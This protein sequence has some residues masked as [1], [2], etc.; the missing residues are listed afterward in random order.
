[1]NV[2]I[3]SREVGHGHP[4]YVIAELSANHGQDYQRARELLYVAK[5]AGADAVK[6]Q[7][8]TADTITINCD[9]APFRVKDGT[10][11][12]GRTL[13]ELYAEAFT[14]WEWQPELKR[15]ADALGIDLFSTPFDD[16]AVEF[17]E[18]L[19]PPAHKIASFELVDHALIARVASTGRSV[20][21]STGMAT[22]TE[23]DAAVNVAR[24]AGAGGVVL[25]RC[26]SAYPARPSEMDLRTIPHMATT[27]RVPVG[28]S[29]HTLTNTAAIAA[30]TLGAAVVEKHL[31]L[32]RSAAGPDSAFS[33]EPQEFRS[34]VEAVREAEGA[35][36]DVRYGPS[37]SEQPS[38][39][40]RRSLFA[41]NDVQAGETFTT[42]NVRSIRP[43][44]G[45]PPEFLPLVLGRTATSRISRGTPLSWDL[46]G[47]GVP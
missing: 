17:L 3:G 41:V 38:V 26:N 20:I 40:F 10:L 29:D 36:G 21:M 15:E 43:A 16:T 18:A 11:W 7:T 28:L 9:A 31:T 44:D 25:L 27:W 14:P 23:I 34:L 4:V 46:I 24:T 5:D 8:Y 22:L 32:D 42:R 45:L 13:Y 6:L 2:K 35:L 12:A 33:L 47:P 37:E 39:A 30:V 19:D 1:M